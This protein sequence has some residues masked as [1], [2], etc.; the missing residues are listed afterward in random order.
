MARNARTAS[1]PKVSIRKA[2]KEVAARRAPAGLSMGAERAGARRASTVTGRPAAVSLRTQ[3]WASGTLGPTP[4]RAA[5]TP[6]IPSISKG[7]AA[8][9]DPYQA[10]TSWRVSGQISGSPG[11]S[12]WTTRT[13]AV[14][15]ICARTPSGPLAAPALGAASGPDGVLAQM[16]ATAIVRVEGPAAF[17]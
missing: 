11:A 7:A 5:A 13:I 16:A 14:A 12:G 4:R 1:R 9:R 6:A 2:T 17:P 15:A 10:A 8:A 3:A